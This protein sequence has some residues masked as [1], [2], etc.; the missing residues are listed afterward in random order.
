[1]YQDSG[2]STNELGDII[3]V[4]DHILVNNRTGICIRKCIN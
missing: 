2:I 3:I 1:M 4:L